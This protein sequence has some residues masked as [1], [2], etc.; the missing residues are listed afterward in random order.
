MDGKEHEGEGLF[1]FAFEQFEFHRANNPEI[2][3]A[4][5]EFCGA[6][7]RNESA[8]VMFP[9][10]YALKSFN[11]TGV[12]IPRVS[13]QSARKARDELR[14]TGESVLDLP[15]FKDLQGAISHFIFFL[16]ILVKNEETRKKARLLFAVIIR[17]IQV[18]KTSHS[19][20]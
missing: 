15:I 9:V 12:S 3:K 16:N 18:E 13:E 10:F 17:M 2:T 7:G 8:P 20:K 4:I 5:D 1:N 11:E 6:A 19:G 14:E